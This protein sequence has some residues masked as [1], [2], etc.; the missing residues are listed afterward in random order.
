MDVVK[1][2]NSTVGS[3]AGSGLDNTDRLTIKSQ[4]Q[5][6]KIHKKFNKPAG[7]ASEIFQEQ[8]ST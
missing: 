2:G 6:T 3:L 7:K 8:K 4:P 5:E 1:F